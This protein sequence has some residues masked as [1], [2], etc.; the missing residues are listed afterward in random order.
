MCVYIYW[1]HTG[2]VLTSLAVKCRGQFAICSDGF[3][4][5]SVFFA[6]RKLIG[7]ESTLKTDDK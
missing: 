1:G 2:G 4:V 6:R 7:Q 3:G 5:C